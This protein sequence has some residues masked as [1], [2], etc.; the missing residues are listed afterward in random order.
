MQ[1][2]AN[3]AVHEPRFDYPRILYPKVTDCTPTS[4]C[5]VRPPTLANDLSFAFSIT[6]PEPAA[7]SGLSYFQ[8]NISSG[9]SPLSF[10]DTVSAAGLATSV[11]AYSSPRHQSLVFSS[12]TGTNS[13]LQADPAIM[14][15]NASGIVAYR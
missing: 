15:S 2:G 4:P 14:T 9:Q 3:F 5:L 12:I 6:G 7:L 8:W 10:I 1:Q 13:V 11:Y